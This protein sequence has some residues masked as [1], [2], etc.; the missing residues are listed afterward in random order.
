MG[1]IAVIDTETTWND[2]VMSIGTVIADSD[3]FQALDA[4]YH[5]LTP[6]CEIGGM[7]ENVLFLEG[8]LAPKVCTRQEAMEDLTSWLKG[9]DVS[10]VFAYNASFDRNHLP[11]LGYLK[12][13][14][15]M[16]LAAYRQHNP[17][18]SCH[19]ECFSTGRLKRGYGVEAIY[20]MLSGDCRYREVHNAVCDAM[21]ELQIMRLLGHGMEDYI[22]LSTGCK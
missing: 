14:D 6:E 18:I 19:A 20:R 21:D 9:Y 11:E 10:A 4:R 5:V 15:I 13:F 8:A 22:E 3:T 12:W 16:R 2:L 17:K 7:Y 1:K